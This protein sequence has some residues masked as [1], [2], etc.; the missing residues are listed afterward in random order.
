ME[1]V[2]LPWGWWSGRSGSRVFSPSRD[3]ICG[4]AVAAFPELFL[5]KLFSSRSIC[6]CCINFFV[7]SIRQK[8]TL[9]SAVHPLFLRTTESNNTAGNETGGNGQAALFRPEREGRRGS[10]R[11]PLLRQEPKQLSLS[12]ADGQTTTTAAEG[13]SRC[14]LRFDPRRTTATTSDG[15]PAATIDLGWLRREGR[16][17]ITH[18]AMVSQHLAFDKILA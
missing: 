10:C 6:L 11:L 18:H 15:A 16:L 17:G 9:L 2:A 7:S 3:R 4:E 8:T 5:L 13:E 14:F 1:L 12:G